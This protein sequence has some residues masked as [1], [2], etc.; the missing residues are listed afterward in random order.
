MSWSCN[1]GRE[2]RQKFSLRTRINGMVYLLTGLDIADLM[3]RHL[4]TKPEIYYCTK[5]MHVVHIHGV[6]S[7]TGVLSFDKPNTF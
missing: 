7:N 5:W 1:L 6:E 2:K 4:Q 3:I